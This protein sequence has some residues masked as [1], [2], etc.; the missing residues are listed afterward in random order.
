MP[1]GNRPFQPRS[2]YVVSES[3][4]LA[5]IPAEEVRAIRP[6]LPP[7]PPP[8]LAHR[9]PVTIEEVV[10]GDERGVQPRELSRNSVG[11]FHTPRSRL[12]IATDPL[13]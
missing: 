13:R 11:T 10:L 1:P 4:S 9:L 6:S 5:N 8:D 2:E 12:P 7:V 3:L